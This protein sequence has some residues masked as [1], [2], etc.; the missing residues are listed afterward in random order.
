MVNRVEGNEME[1]PMAG[2]GEGGSEASAAPPGPHPSH[3]SPHSADWAMSDCPMHKMDL[4]HRCDE[5][6]WPQLPAAHSPAVG[7]Y[8]CGGSQL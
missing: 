4:A 2:G 3:A 7:G 6:A 1:S 8:G 5:R